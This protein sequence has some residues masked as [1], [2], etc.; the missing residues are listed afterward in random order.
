MAKSKGWQLM[1]RCY[2]HT[3]QGQ[4]YDIWRRLAVQKFEPQSQGQFFSRYGLKFDRR[5]INT[6]VIV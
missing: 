4:P 3:E 6:I 2:V 1:I 5:E